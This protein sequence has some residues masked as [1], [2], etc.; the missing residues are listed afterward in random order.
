MCDSWRDNFSSFY[1]DVGDPPSDYH[2]LDRIDND[3]GY[4][5]DNVRWSTQ[6]EQVGNRR[7]SIR[8]DFEG[9]NKTLKEL[10]DLL[11]INYFKAYDLIVRKKIKVDIAVKI[12]TGSK[13]TSN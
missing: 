2:S 6:L 7:V 3:D 8:I 5:K 1:S 13:E 4:H 12:L 9:R 11:S 10:C